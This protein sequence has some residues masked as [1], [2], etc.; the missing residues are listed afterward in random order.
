MEPTG[1][2][3]SA[4]LIGLENWIF[5]YTYPNSYLDDRQFRVLSHDCAEIIGREPKLKLS[6]SLDPSQ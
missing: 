4:Y 5:S 6:V 2:I 1:T 3:F